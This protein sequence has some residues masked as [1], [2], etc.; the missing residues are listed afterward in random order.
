M[1]QF[2]QSA[3]LLF[4]MHPT[5]P[6]RNPVTTTSGPRYWPLSST[7][8]MWAPRDSSLPSSPRVIYTRGP[9]VR[10]ISSARNEL[11]QCSP[12]TSPPWLGF[13]RPWT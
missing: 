7:T 11:E 4:P 12:R 5:S 6:P 3:H 13:A 10:S 8:Y 1:G 2:P 9:I